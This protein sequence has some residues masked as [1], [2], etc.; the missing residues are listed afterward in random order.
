MTEISDRF[1]RV[2]AAFTE[3]VRV[4]PHESWENPAP[5]DGWVAR[6]VVRHLVE[7]I[8]ALLYGGPGI[9]SPT[10]PSVDEDPI[11]AWDTFV[12][13]IT[14][15]LGDP[16]IATREFDTPPGPTSFE[17]ALDQLGTPDVLLHTW[18]LAR[19]TGLDEA[20]LADEVHQL[21]VGIQP[22]DEVLRRSGHYGPKVAVSDDADE[23]TKLLAF[24]GRR[25][26]FGRSVGT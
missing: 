15:S 24:I 26:S 1:Q 17:R 22:Y 14:A 11:G 25:P 23:Q 4:V 6:D 20:L 9:V 12:V 13:A 2:A 18:D 5:C 10:I 3:R 21:Y 16:D 19:A 8:P 7:W